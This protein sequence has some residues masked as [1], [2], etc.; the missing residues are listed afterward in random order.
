MQPP[1]AP[2]PQTKDDEISE[3]CEGRGDELGFTRPFNAASLCRKTEDEDML[4]D[5]G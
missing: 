4:D 1:P 2:I 5:D 3:I